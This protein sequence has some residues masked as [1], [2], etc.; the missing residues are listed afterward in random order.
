MSTET[1]DTL[2]KLDTALANVVTQ[3]SE[4]TAEH[5]EKAVDLALWAY[6]VEAA[7]ELAVSG[8]FGVGLVAA[9]VYCGRLAYGRFV[10]AGRDETSRSAGEG[11]VFVGVVLSIAAGIGGAIGAMITAGLLSP[12]RWLAAFGHPEL[13]IATNTL[14]AAGLL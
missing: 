5:G 6:Q 12:T 1:G 9:A 14:K 10:Y 3:L 4:L 7:R 8:V 2:E 13:L 11:A